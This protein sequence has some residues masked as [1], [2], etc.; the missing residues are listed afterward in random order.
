MDNIYKHKRQTG[1]YMKIKLDDNGKIQGIN[2][3]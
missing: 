1:K 3:P 2:V